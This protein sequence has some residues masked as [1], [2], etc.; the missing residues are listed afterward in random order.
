M[1]YFWLT[2]VSKNKPNSILIQRKW[3]YNTSNLMGYKSTSKMA[4][5]SKKKKKKTQINNPTLWIAA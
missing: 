3:K 2:N 4:V 5:Y 1:T